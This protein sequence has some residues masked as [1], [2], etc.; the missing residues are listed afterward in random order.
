MMYT[1]E[2]VTLT[3]RRGDAEKNAEKSHAYQNLGAQ[4]KRRGLGWRHRPSTQFGG[5]FGVRQHLSAHAPEDGQN[6]PSTVTHASL[7]SPWI[8]A[9]S[10][11]SGFDSLNCVLRVFLRVSAS[12]RQT[13]G[14]FGSGFSRLGAVP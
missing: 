3:R 13:Y 7:R 11:I 10:A 5:Y 2:R 1:V 9:D 8:S 6:Q 4:R 14:L 12:P